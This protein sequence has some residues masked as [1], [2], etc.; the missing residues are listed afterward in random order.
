RELL[1][2]VGDEAPLIILRDLLADLLVLDR[3]VHDASSW[4]VTAP[5]APRTRSPTIPMCG[6]T[7]QMASSAQSWLVASEHMVSA[8]G[9]STASMM[10]ARLIS[11]TGSASA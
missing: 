5:N 2:D 6:F 8:I 11:V 10:S 4:S 3:L 9:P 7:W 1:L